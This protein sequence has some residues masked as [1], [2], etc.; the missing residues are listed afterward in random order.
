MVVQDGTTPLMHASKTGELEV[1]KLLLQ[2]LAKIDTEENVFSFCSLLC[3]SLHTLIHLLGHSMD[4]LI[5]P[6]KENI[7]MC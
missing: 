2:K 7:K 1:T 4:F 6:L 3:P 5:L